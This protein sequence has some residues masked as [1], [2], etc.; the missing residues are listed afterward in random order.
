MQRVW[1]L[2]LETTPGHRPWRSS[3]SGSNPNLMDILSQSRRSSLANSTNSQAGS[4]RPMLADMAAEQRDPPNAPFVRS[5]SSFTT[6]P[7]K[8]GSTETSG[9]SL[10]FHYLPHKFSNTL[11]SAGARNRKAKKGVAHIPKLGGGVEAFKSGEARIPGENDEGYDGVSGNYS[12]H[13]RGHKRLRWNR[14]KWTLFAANTLL[15]LYSLTGL[16]MCLLTWFDIWALSGIIR[17]GNRPEL[18]IS[19]LAASLAIMTSLVGWAGLLLNNRPFLAVYTFLL[20]I[21]FIFL[22][23]PGYMTYK[24]KEF[25][26]E[27]KLNSQWSRDLGAEGRLRVQNSLHC[28][29]YFSP[30]VEATVSQ[31]CYARTTLPGCKLPYMQYERKVLKIWYTTVFALVPLHIFI[32]V[33][34]LLCSNHVT[35]RFGKG[36]MPKAYRLSLN[37]M[38]VI[39]D[40]YANQLAEQYGTDVPTDVARSKSNLQLDSMPTMPYSPLNTRQTPVDHKQYNSI[41]SRTP[42]T[43]Q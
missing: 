15:T 13:H 25:N 42:D 3:E 14:F 23:M 16:V 5:Q 9:V 6:P 7:G 20:W 24:R 10:T 35:Y 17:V 43:A 39:M 19:T 33:A 1:S 22:L 36:M 29:G 37:S 21:V 40:N 8:S 4:T 31:T 11:L 26:L 32:I 27:G 2:Y 30:Y 38:A 34:G 41:G 12:G 28:C 18:V